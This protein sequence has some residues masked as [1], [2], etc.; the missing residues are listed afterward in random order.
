MNIYEKLVEI[1][2]CI[3]GFTKDKKSFNYSYVSGTQVLSKIYDKM[4]ELKVIL[5]PHIVHGTKQYEILQQ[6][7][8]DKYGKAKHTTD[9][10]VTSEME[11]IWINAEKP[12]ERSAISW[13][14]FGQQD[15]ISKAFGSGLTYSERYF[16]MKYFSVPTDADDPDNK[17]PKYDDKCISGK[18]DNGTTIYATKQEISLATITAKAHGLDNIKLKALMKEVLNVETF[19]DIKKSDLIKLEAAMKKIEV[20]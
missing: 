19:A 1:R 15:D 6:D 3:D 14:L 18:G 12:E 8:V 16:L 11:Y 9:Y 10:I 20:E 17:K 7:I 13:G 4:N 2:K 5:E